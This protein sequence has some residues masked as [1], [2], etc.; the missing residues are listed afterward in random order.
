M[1]SPKKGE[2]LRCVSS[3]DKFQCV[4]TDAGTS[5]MPQRS[6]SALIRSAKTCSIDLPVT[7]EMALSLP[8]VDFG[9]RIEDRF[10]SVAERCA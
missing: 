7:P 1:R 10:S 2:W 8:Q 4:P 3:N 6:A 9:A 5:T